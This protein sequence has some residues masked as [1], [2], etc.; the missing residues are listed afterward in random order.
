MI[1]IGNS[2]GT[3][4]L[5]DALKEKCRSEWEKYCR[6]EFVQRIGDGTLPEKC[7]RHYL[8]Q[9]YLFLIHF[10]RAWALAAYKADNLTDMRTAAENLNAHINVEMN[11]HLKY[12]TGWGITEQDLES[13]EESPANMA[14]T[15]YVLERGLAGDILDLH[16]ALAPCIIGYA[17]I[18][19]SLFKDSATRLAG[20]PYCEW[21][22][23]YA[24]EEYQTVALNAICHLDVLAS[25]RM[26]TNRMVSLAKTFKQATVLE[27]GFWEMG[28]HL[29]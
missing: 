1:N 26:G 7:F 16:V 28:L 11:L 13:L 24:G 20:N 5:F 25:S 27:I 23:M 4:T 15:R 9:D 10:S 2:Q 18:G 3:D 22:E 8:M 17:I 29:L 14:Y 21:I 6:H 12:C 19:S